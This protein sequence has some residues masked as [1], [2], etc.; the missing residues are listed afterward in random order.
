MLQRFGIEFLLFVSLA[1]GI[2]LLYVK[3]LHSRLFG[4]VVEA[5]APDPTDEEVADRLYSADITAEQRA[6]SNENEAA[7]K[8]ASAAKLRKARRPSAG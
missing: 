6:I 1:G 4:T 7:A 5:A 3:L 8:T 2:Y